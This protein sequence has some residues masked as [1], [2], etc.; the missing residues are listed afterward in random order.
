MEDDTKIYGAQE[1]VQTGETAQSS[2]SSVE[3]GEDEMA[4]LS[5]E[6]P[7]VL[8][9]GTAVLP[10]EVTELTSGGMKLLDAYRLYDLRRVKRQVA[11]LQTKYDAEL[12]NRAN[13]AAAV[14]SV[15]GG[16]AYEKDYYTSQEWDKLPQNLREKF[17][18]NGKIFEFMKKWSVHS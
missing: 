3:N 16:Q 4:T 8:R 17:I 13:A 15:R 5:R 12:E 7:E 6:Y 11:E 14:G 9:G 18:K 2:E 1:P 10:P